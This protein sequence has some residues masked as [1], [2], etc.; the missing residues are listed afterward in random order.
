MRGGRERWQRENR[1]EVGE[2]KRLTAPRN[3]LAAELR[4][5]QP[6]GPS[7]PRWIYTNTSFMTTTTT[8]PRLQLL[9]TTETSVGLWAHMLLARYDRQAIHSKATFQLLPIAYIVT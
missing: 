8:A 7:Q 3:H 5:R 2:E 1:D 4:I 9:A 6:D